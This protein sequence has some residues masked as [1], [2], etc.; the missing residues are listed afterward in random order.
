MRNNAY[1][2]RTACIYRNAIILNYDSVR[3]DR[4]DRDSKASYLFLESREREDG[5]FRISLTSRPTLIFDRSIDDT[6]RVREI[7]A[8]VHR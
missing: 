7:Y 5:I 1:K 6:T 2:C 3:V 8:T 4:G